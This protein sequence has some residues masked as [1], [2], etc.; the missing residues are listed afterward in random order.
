MRGRDSWFITIGNYQSILHL[1]GMYSQLIYII[2]YIHQLW[3]SWEQALLRLESCQDV[4]LEREGTY[5]NLRR[6][7]T[8]WQGT[9]GECRWSIP[10]RLSPCGKNV[11]VAHLRCVLWY[12]GER[13]AC[14]CGSRLSVHVPRSC[15]SVDTS[16]WLGSASSTDRQKTKVNLMYGKH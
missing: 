4:Y 2:L 12:S 16:N 15:D 3:S 9:V 7:L 5:E 13:E 11:S 14:W 6:N 1:A 8:I 10:S